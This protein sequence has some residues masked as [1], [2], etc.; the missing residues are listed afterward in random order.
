MDNLQKMRASVGGKLKQKPKDILLRPT[1]TPPQAP[2]GE[3]APEQR[4]LPEEKIPTLYPVRL[5]TPITT[6]QLGLLT[7]TA[8]RLRKGGGD[9]I[10]KGAVIRC[11]IDLLQDIPFSDGDSVTTEDELK[12]LLRQKMIGK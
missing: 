10:N 7:T 12:S 2:K 9:L 11:L 5:Q 8:Q 3:R 4:K 6:E 1:E